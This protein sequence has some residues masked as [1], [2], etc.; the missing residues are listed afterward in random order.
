M[1]STEFCYD[2]RD[3][4]VEDY[5]EKIKFYEKHSLILEKS[6]DFENL[7]SRNEFIRRIF[8]I[9]QCGIAYNK[10]E[11]YKK[12][13]SIFEKLIDLIEKNH[14]KYNLD[15]QREYYYN[16]SLFENAQALYY[17][18]KYKEAQKNLKIIQ[19]TGFANFAQSNWYMYAKHALLLKYLNDIIIILA[20]YLIFIPAIIST[21]TSK[22]KL[23]FS[24]ISAVLFVTFLLNP[25]KR[26]SRLLRKIYIK[27]FNK[28]LEKRIDT[29]TYYT[30]KIERDPTDYVSLI[31]R[32]IEYNL[33]DEYEKSLVDLNAA[34]KV[35]PTNIDG[36][37]YR[38]IC[39]QKLK[40]YDKTFEDYSALIALKY[41]DV[42]EIYHNRGYTYEILE[43][44]ESALKDYD[45]AIELEPYKAFYLFNRAFLYQ[46]QEKNIEAIKDYD[47][48]ILFEPENAKALTNRGEAHY[49]L[50][51]KEKAYADFIKAQEFGYEDAIENLKKLDF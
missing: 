51:N 15:L 18:K 41:S 22:E 34:L 49:A 23:I 19:D 32:G 1:I 4:G 28:N 46:S 17:L 30:Q 8:I 35:N 42:A 29:I 10:I 25:S 14:Q 48:V 31:E 21:F 24:L 27:K 11:N 5:S 38:A 36:L 40:M 39:Y 47:M 50:G 3:I 26:L 44:Y 45:K 2:F 33:N 37:Y 43:Q 16:N 7:S 13:S 12:A 6:E 9:Y 20:F